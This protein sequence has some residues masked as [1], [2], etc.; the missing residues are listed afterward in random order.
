MAKKY[1]K[2]REQCHNFYIK[3]ALEKKDKR[4]Y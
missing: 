3:N 1:K 2:S 4:N